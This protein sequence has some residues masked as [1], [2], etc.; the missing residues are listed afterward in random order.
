[1]AD[2]QP[3]SDSNPSRGNRNR[4]RGRGGGGGG[5]GGG[6]S[7]TRGR[8]RGGRGRG[9]SNAGAV[10]QPNVSSAPQPAHTKP[11]NKVLTR[12]A[13]EGDDT[14]SS[15]GEVCFICAEPIKFHSIAP[16]NHKTCHICGL[17]MRALYKTKDCPIAE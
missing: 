17:R 7:G 11:D 14:A 6:S 5:G 13:T 1:M 4:G 8:G 2:S 15:D 12:T 9:G 3:T 16:C 10:P